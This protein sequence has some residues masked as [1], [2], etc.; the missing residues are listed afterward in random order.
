[1]MVITSLMIEL[2]NIAVLCCFA[3]PLDLIS[4]FVSLVIICQFDNFIFASMANECYR[5]LCLNQEFT[6]EV[7]V[8]NHTTSKK[9]ENHELSQV[10][11]DG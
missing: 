4:N 8:I 3:D 6:N 10:V 11:K 5:E 7:F 2:G 1:M 9:C